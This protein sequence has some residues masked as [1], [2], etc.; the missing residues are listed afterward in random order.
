M[1]S[2]FADE[3]RHSLA[4][5]TNSPT[6][7]VICNTYYA[8]GLYSPW[9]ERCLFSFVAKAMHTLKYVLYAEVKVL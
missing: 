9:G 2:C 8:V 4:Q 5:F 3:S 7:H 1:L 6:V